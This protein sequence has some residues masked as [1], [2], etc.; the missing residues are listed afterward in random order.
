MTTRTDI[1]LFRIEQVELTLEQLRS[2]GPIL[3]LD[4][5]GAELGFYFSP[6][7]AGLTAW[8]QLRQGLQRTSDFALY[9]ENEKVESAQ[10]HAVLEW[11]GAALKRLT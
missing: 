6:S 10:E 3:H 2:D 1:N 5:G 11:L 4:I 7:R 8:Q 9:I